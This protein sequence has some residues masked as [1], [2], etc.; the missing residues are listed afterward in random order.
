MRQCGRPH[1][2]EAI[3]TFNPSDGCFDLEHR[4]VP[5]IIQICA[6]GPVIPTVYERCL[7]SADNGNRHG[8]LRVEGP[9]S[10]AE[11]GCHHSSVYTWM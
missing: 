11:A 7:L 8:A 1:Q 4:N 2:Q 5:A 10:R 9:G 3:Y 6:C